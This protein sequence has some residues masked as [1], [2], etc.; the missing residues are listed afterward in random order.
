[1]VEAAARP[2]PYTSKAA[3][4][5]GGGVR[6]GRWGAAGSSAGDARPAWC[7]AVGNAVGRAAERRRLVLPLKPRCCLDGTWEGRRV[8]K[9]GL[10]QQSR[11]RQTEQNNLAQMPEKTFHQ[12]TRLTFIPYSIFIPFI[13]FTLLNFF[14]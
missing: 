1:M 4:L 8:G 13:L 3:V 10:D 12:L 5:A 6:L 9:T 11:G 2:K 7:E 14:F